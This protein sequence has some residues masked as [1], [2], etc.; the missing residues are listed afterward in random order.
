MVRVSG[1]SMAPQ[2]YLGGWSGGVPTCLQTCQQAP[3]PQDASSCRSTTFD[4]VFGSTGRAH[5]RNG[6]LL[7]GWTIVP[8]MPDDYV[9]TQLMVFDFETSAPAG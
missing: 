9:Q 3:W 8:H 1:P 4:E 7:D 6:P 2:C 5:G